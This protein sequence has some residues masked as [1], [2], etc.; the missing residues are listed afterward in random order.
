MSY[1]DKS[2]SLKRYCKTYDVK[3]PMSKEMCKY[4]IDLGFYCIVLY[5]FTRMD[6]SCYVGLKVICD[7]SYENAI[8]LDISDIKHLIRTWPRSTGNYFSNKYNKL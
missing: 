6:G 2:T 1:I 3:I 5:R 7:N 4:Y 8:Y